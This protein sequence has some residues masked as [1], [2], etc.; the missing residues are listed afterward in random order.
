MSFINKNNLNIPTYEYFYEEAFNALEKMDIND[1]YREKVSQ[2]IALYMCMFDYMEIDAKTFRSDK[3][4]IFEERIVPVLKTFEGVQELEAINAEGYQHPMGKFTGSLEGD[5]LCH[6]E[7]VKNDSKEILSHGLSHEIAHFITLKLNE[8]GSYRRWDCS[9]LLAIDEMFTEFYATKLIELKKELIGL[10]NIK[11]S[12]TIE[13]S[14]NELDSFY[15]DIEMIS[16]DKYYG[17]IEGFAPILDSV[18]H[19]EIM[20]CKIFGLDTLSLYKENLAALNKD[21]VDVMTNMAPY[22]SY[23]KINKTLT[24]TL[25]KVLLNK[26][27]NIPIEDTISDYLILR[28]NLREFG[29]PILQEDTIRVL[30]SLM[31]E[32]ILDMDISSIDDYSLEKIFDTFETCYRDNDNTYSRFSKEL[33]A[34]W[35]EIKDTSNHKLITDVPSLSIDEILDRDNVYLTR[36]NVL[37]DV[38]KEFINLKLGINGNNQ[39]LIDYFKSDE[40]NKESFC[41]FILSIDSRGLTF[42]RDLMTS[43]KENNLGD[44]FEEVFID[45]LFEE[46]LKNNNT[47][48]SADIIRGIYYLDENKDKYI[49]KLEPIIKENPDAFFNSLLYLSSYKDE[50]KVLPTIIKDL[51]VINFSEVLNSRGNDFLQFCEDK[52]FGCGTGYSNIGSD[53]AI[54]NREYNLDC[55]KE[56]IKALLQ[57]GFS[58]DRENEN[59]ESS[60]AKFIS[61]RNF[62]MQKNVEVLDLIKDILIKSGEYEENI[63]TLKSDVFMLNKDYLLSNYNSLDLDGNKI[64]K[65]ISLDLPSLQFKDKSYV[66]GVVMLNNPENLSTLKEELL[67]DTSKLE[68]VINLGVKHKSLKILAGVI[69]DDRFKKYFPQEKKK[70]IVEALKDKDFKEIK[71]NNTEKEL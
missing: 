16:H 50:E 66:E 62:K 20:K 54:G 8:D 12:Y 1:P 52:Q 44:R 11:N 70:E 71:L 55:E 38:S 47:R 41:D 45:N 31:A 17:N 23:E 42:S 56:S 67:K 2:D 4:Q 21:M 5:S 40:F 9:N 29:T 3:K 10:D 48:L 26:Y 14:P 53:R 57:T 22:D 32:K 46:T 43:L 68:E 58:F 30:D 36:I 19:E 61:R 34:N 15:P 7:L 27:D 59:Y 6:I 69:D 60:F 51:S 37:D 28:K 33:N 49:K 65:S 64:E 25:E 35:I 63:E 18:L 24:C 13:I 39:V